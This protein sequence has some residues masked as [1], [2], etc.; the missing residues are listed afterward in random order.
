ME[1]PVAPESKILKPEPSLVNERTE[2]DEPKL[3]CCKAESSPPTFNKPR[4]LAELPNRANDRM[5]K[6]DP[7]R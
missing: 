3:I 6:L 4:T 2:S 5:D 1:E 7:P